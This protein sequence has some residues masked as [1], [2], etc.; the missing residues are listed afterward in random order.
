M[1]KKYVHYILSLLLLFLLA[2]IVWPNR[3]ITLNIEDF[4]Y[5]KMWEGPSLTKLTSGRIQND[6]N[7]NLGKELLG[8]V[9]FKYQVI[10][11]EAETEKV[12]R[13]DQTV[14]I[15]RERFD[16]GGFGQSDV[17]WKEENEQYFILADVENKNSKLG[18]LKETLFNTGDLNIWGEGQQDLPQESDPTSAGSFESFLE[19]SYDKLEVDANDIKGYRILNDEDKHFIK[20]ALSD[21]QSEALTANIYSFYGKNL[22]AVLDEQFL[23]ID[24]TDIG[25]QVQ[26]SGQIRTLNIAG[27]ESEEEAEFFGGIID[28]GPLQV[29]LS[30]VEEN[31]YE[32]AYDKSFVGKT[33]I[34]FI[35]LSLIFAVFLIAKYK[36]DGVVGFLSVAI[37]LLFIA[38]GLK[39]LQVTLTLNLI[40]M[41]SI[42][43]GILFYIINE[44]IHSI[45]K[46]NKQ[47]RVDLVIYYRDQNV[48]KKVSALYTIQILVGLSLLFSTWQGKN[49][50]NVLLLSGLFTFLTIDYLVS[51]IYKFIFFVKEENDE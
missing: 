13:L 27:F 44:I 20:L 25:E 6:L 19:Q 34:L 31:E 18:D 41:S 9:R 17:Y 35:G 43:I 16:A 51:L 3:T 37:W 23:V 49:I 39:F 26:M 28:N 29:E 21:V 7:L 45:D 50:A 36:V 46:R 4:H 14:E 38:A 5:Q 22:L 42:A 15:I 40:M 48:H 47:S 30:Q 8:G 12:E 33:A 10:F 24:G 32:G 1:G 11:N 2:L